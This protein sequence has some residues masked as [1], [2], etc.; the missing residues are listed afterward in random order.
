MI[1]MV[2]DIETTGLNRF[3]D[4]INIAGV[5]VPEY[6][7][8]A[9]PQT[10]N[11]FM[12][13]LENLPEK[14]T[15]LWA[16]GKFD[17]LFLEQQW[18]IPKEYLTIDED[19]MVLAY[20]FE[21]GK[22]KSLK[23]LAK[24]HCGAEDWDISKK[25]KTQMSLT[26]LDYNKKDLYY[27]WEVW[28]ELMRLVHA[29]TEKDRILR[30]YYGL[31]LPS[32]RMYRDVERHGMHVDTEKI[33]QMLPEYYAKRDSLAAQLKSYADINWNSSSQVAK[34]FIDQLHMP[35]LKR[36]EKGAVSI[37]GEA[38]DDYAYMGYDVAKILVEYKQVVRDI[39]MF[40]EPWLSKSVNSRVYPTFNIDTVRTGRTSCSEPNLQQVPRDKALRT[41]FNAKEGYVLFEADYSQV[42]LRIACQFANESTMHKVYNENGDIHTTTAQA[43]T[44]KQEVT[45]AE[46]RDAKVVNFGF[47]YG[48]SAKG[49]QNYAKTGY[50]MR[51]TEQQATE[52]RNRYFATYRDLPVWYEHQKGVC[53]RDGGVYTLFGRFRELSDIYSNNYKLKSG[54]ERCSFNTPVQSTASDILLSAAIEINDCLPDVDIVCT[55]HD[56]ILM[57]V[58]EA[59]KDEYLERVRNIMLHPKLLD[60]FG[61][62][63]NVPLD[64][65]IGVGPWGTH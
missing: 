53:K 50:G 29:H 33:Q 27:T 58:P 59:K 11:Q 17:T 61:V 35:I 55:V 41:L 7:Y 38:L 14:P 28:K 32:F 40:L 44:G 16:N 9:F 56:S 62:K 3:K 42:E 25:E 48:M 39:G 24:R 15:M 2:I 26:L 64:V 20:C 1:H 13:L 49:F 46:R 54:A 57:E 60:F 51:I 10:P 5:Y 23:E 43:I 30:L 52:M 19:I 21:M 47:L 63:L 36:T 12:G 37:D 6:D 8:Y 22:R 4:T 31:A 45:K 65:D 18:G 34:V